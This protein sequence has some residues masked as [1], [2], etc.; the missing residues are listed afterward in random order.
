VT[1]TEGGD[2]S[3]APA[4]PEIPAPAPAAPRHP[5]PESPTVAPEPPAAAEPEHPEPEQDEDAPT[6]APARRSRAWIAAA[7]LMLVVATFLGVLA[8]GTRAELDRE[9]DERQQVE[10]V[11]ARFATAFVTYDYRNLDASLTRIKRD[12]SARFG[13]EYERL[14]RTSVRT[15]I[16]ETRAR[17]AGTVTDVFLGSIDD[18]T[19][20]ALI[21]V[22]VEREGAG[23]RLP[24]AGTYFQLDL[25]EQNGRWKVDNVT[26]INF[27]QSV[28]PLPGAGGP[29]APAPTTTTSVPR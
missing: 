1:D 4:P 16:Q 13:G 14:F 9:R 17:S 24:V 25:V 11:A 19:A 28:G 20:S 5:E 10:Q 15:L 21:V 23:G 3:V 22:N 26:S 6:D 27:T 29:A 2:E 8:A 12:A 18:E 7:A